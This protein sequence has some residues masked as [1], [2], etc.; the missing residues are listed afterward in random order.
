MIWRVVGG[1]RSNIKI[2]LVNGNLRI[3]SAMVIVI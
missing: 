2:L 3:L 1:V